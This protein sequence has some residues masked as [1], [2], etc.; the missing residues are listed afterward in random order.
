MALNSWFPSNSWMILTRFGHFFHDTTFED[1]L[2]GMLFV[3]WDQLNI[4]R[5]TEEDQKKKFLDLNWDAMKRSFGEYYLNGVCKCSRLRWNRHRMHRRYFVGHNSRRHQRQ[6]GRRKKNGVQFDLWNCDRL[7]AIGVWN[8]E[9]KWKGNSL[10]KQL[11]NC[12]HGE[13]CT[14]SDHSHRILQKEE[15][16]LSLSRSLHE[17]AVQCWKKEW[18][19]MAAEVRLLD[20]HFAQAIWLKNPLTNSNIG[21]LEV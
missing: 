16:A 11:I 12:R 18:N 1:D 19:L 9:R 7:M 13:Y 4:G 3:D 14:C 10:V 17:H 8:W 21:D 2:C 6:R 15:V 5:E 20:G